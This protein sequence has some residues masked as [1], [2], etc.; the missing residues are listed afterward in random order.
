MYSYGGVSL[1]L[2]VMIAWG[3]M[4][5]FWIISMKVNSSIFSLSALSSL[6]HLKLTPSKRVDPPRIEPGTP[7][8]PIPW[9]PML[10]HACDAARAAIPYVYNRPIVSNNDILKKTGEKRI[11]VEVKIKRWRWIGYVLWM[12]NESN[13][14]TAL[15]WKPEGKKESWTSLNY[16]D[17][18]LLKVKGR[19]LNRVVG[20]RPEP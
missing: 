2:E 8:T 10:S 14:R 13:C 4:T 5:K 17:W 1:P 16:M 18:E 12:E 19:N 20:M 9:P 3:K 11:S 7:R 6:S 15:R